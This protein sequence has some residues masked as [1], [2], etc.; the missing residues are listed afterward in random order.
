M[1]TKPGISRM[2]LITVSIGYILG[3]IAVFSGIDYIML[4]IGTFFVASGAGVLN[5]YYERDIDAKMDRT[6]Q[7]PLPAN[8]LSPRLCLLYGFMLSV[9]GSIL[10]FLFVN[11]LT[12]NLNNGNSFIIRFYD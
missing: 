4:L 9:V 11:S 5:S 7:R 2:Q 3:G 12:D 6:Q 10:L 1:L 8:R